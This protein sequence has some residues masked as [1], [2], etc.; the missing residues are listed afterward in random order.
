MKWDLIRT[1]ALILVASVVE[2]TAC[3]PT[4]HSTLRRQMM[5]AEMAELWVE[6]RDLATRDLFYGPGGRALAPNP[7]AVYQHVKTKS[8]GVNP[9]YT[10]ADPEGLEW[11]IKQGPEA[12]TEVVASR[13]IWAA[14][15]HQPP[16]YYLHTWTLRGTRDD[17][18]QT[19]GR[20]RPKLKTLKDVGEWSWH[21]NPFVGTRPYRGLLALMM[22]L[23]QSDIKT[24]NNSLYEVRDEHGGRPRRYVVRDLGATF[25]ETGRLFPMRGDVDL[26]E[27][28]RFILG[29]DQGFVRFN[30]RGRHQEI[31]RN[32][33]TPEDVRWMCDWLGKIRDEQWQDAFRAGGYA[34]PYAD[35][36]IKRIHEKIE[37]GRQIAKASD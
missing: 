2:L 20:F 4:I 18:S 12:S 24:Q 32:H 28:E 5:P 23:N 30:Y 17:S 35:R 25:G 6:P 26:F 15:Y 36:F 33:V 9:G 16:T 1:V 37:E 8:H 27:K 29:I 31:I 19:P 14:G 22:I 7:K 3:A 13:I 10:V 21:H 11:S 34:G